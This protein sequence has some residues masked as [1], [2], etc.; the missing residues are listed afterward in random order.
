MLVPQVILSLFQTLGYLAL[1]AVAFGAVERTE[2][3]PLVRSLVQGCIFG[4]GAVL[5]MFEPA[6]LAEG[7]QIDGRALIV[8]FGAAFAGWP[9]ALLA[10]VMAGSV[11]ILIGGAGVGPGLAGIVIAAVLGLVWRYWLKP[12]GPLGVGSLLGLGVLISLHLL[13][14]AVLG[15]SLLVTMLIHIAPYIVSASVVDALFLGLFIERELRQIAREQHWRRNA[16]TDPL[17]GLPNRRAFEQGMDGLRVEERP[18]SLLIVDVDHFKLVNDTHGHAAGDYVLQRLA[19]TLRA[20][21]RRKDLLARLG[22]EELSILLPDTGVP[23]ATAVAERLRAAVEGM[24][25]EWQ[26]RPLQ[27]TISIGVAVAKG[28]MPATTLFTQADAAL[29]AAKR[30]GRN[31]VVFAGEVLFEPPAPIRPSREMPERRRARR[32]VA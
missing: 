15:Y 23:E 16:L 13:A 21:L 1:I 8:G 31:R 24:E 12:R 14:S 7:V 9:A 17:T 30:G 22:G 32:R 6:Q 3:P 20:N 18:A 26:G 25:I 27:I 11:R 5:A 29:Y 28:T 19:A 2:W 4:G 10:A